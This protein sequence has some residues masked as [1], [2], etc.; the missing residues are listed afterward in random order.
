MA[1]RDED[2]PDPSGGPRPQFSPEEL[3]THFG[4]ILVAAT[5]LSF[6]YA[7]IHKVLVPVGLKVLGVSKPAYS[8][9]DYTILAGF[10]F[11][12]TLRKSTPPL[13]LLALLA[14]VV[15]G[16]ALWEGY[17]ILSGQVEG[18][19]PVSRVLSTFPLGLMGIWCIVRISSIGR[20]LT[21]WAGL[22]GVVLFFIA[23]KEIGLTSLQDE[24]IARETKIPALN[25][26]ENQ[27]ISEQFLKEYP[28]WRNIDAAD[29][30]LS[31]MRLESNSFDKIDISTGIEVKN[32]GLKPPVFL[33]KPNV[34]HRIPVRNLL[35]KSLNL[36]F[37]I[38]DPL[39][40]SKKKSV[41]FVVPAN[42]EIFLSPQINLKPSDW[43]LLLSDA[44]PEVGH[45]VIVP[46]ESKEKLQS[47]LLKRGG[48]VSSRQ[49]L[50]LR[51]LEDGE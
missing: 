27:Q 21:F 10:F 13:T 17:Q 6:F 23:I 2:L 44:F 51:F 31:K 16:D 1:V 28:V 36:H 47:L 20:I 14:G 40:P 39:S 24:S 22:V 34:P 8:Q 9:I 35:D 3:R 37:F 26:S 43:G 38:F 15:A 33:L 45:S 5:A 18:W 30:G 7:L 50:V 48:L 4:K 29:C 49:P 19:L 41:N 25:G 12:W 32:C 42:T 46:F 11:W